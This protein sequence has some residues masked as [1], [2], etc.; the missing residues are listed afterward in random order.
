MPATP[1]PDCARLTLAVCDHPDATLRLVGRM[2]CAQN[3]GWN[4]RIITPALL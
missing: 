1:L 2:T 4:T 3:P